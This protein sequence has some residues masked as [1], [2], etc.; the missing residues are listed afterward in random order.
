MKSRFGSPSMLW[1]VVSDVRLLVSPLVGEVAAVE[2]GDRPQPGQA[3]QSKGQEGQS[4]GEAGAGEGERNPNVPPTTASVSGP[5][6]ATAVPVPWCSV[7]VLAANG[8]SSSTQSG[9][10][11]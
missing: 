4:H 1:L 3:H 2:L 11:A 5:G 7:H 10:S 9:P 8:S 6:Y